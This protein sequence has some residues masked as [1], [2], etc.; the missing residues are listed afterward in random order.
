MEI[1]CC[2]VAVVVEKAKVR[3]GTGVNVLFS[4]LCANFKE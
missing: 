4:A 2:K 3:M 1:A